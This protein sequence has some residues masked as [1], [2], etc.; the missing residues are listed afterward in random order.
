MADPDA[1]I[2]IPIRV[3]I[4]GRPTPSLLD[5]LENTVAQTVHKRRRE[6]DLHLTGLDGLHPRDREPLRS[7]LAKG[8][9]T[10]VSK[11]EFPDDQAGAPQEEPEPGT[12]DDVAA[13]IRRRFPAPTTDTIRYGAYV[14][15]SGSAVPLLHFLDGNDI[16]SVPISARVTGAPLRFPQGSYSLIA[17]PGG[18]ARIFRGDQRLADLDNPEDLD[19]TVNFVVPAGSGEPTP[20]TQ[21]RYRYRPRLLRVLRPSGE[22]SLTV[23][24]NARYSVEVELWRV[25]GDD[26]TKVT[27]LALIYAFIRYRWTVYHI[28]RN[29]EGVVRGRVIVAHEDAG[30]PVFSHSW[31]KSGEYEVECEVTVDYADASPDPTTESLFEKVIALPVRMATDLALWER[32][33]SVWPESSGTLIEAARIRLREAEA[34]GSPTAGLASG[35]RTAVTEL[36][37]E[38]LGHTSTGPFPI[39][40]IFTERAT[41][42]SHPISLFV[43]PAAGEPY[44][45]RLIDVTYPAFY[46]GEI[47]S[48]PTPASALRAAFETA[49]TSIKNTYPPGRILARI[50]WPGMDSFGISPFD[51][52]IETESFSRTAREWLSAI[53]TGLFVIGV[54]VALATPVTAVVSHIMLAS[55]VFGAVGSVVTIVQRILDGSFDWDRQMAIDLLS[56]AGAVIGGAGTKLGS[57]TKAIREGG[58]LTIEAASRLSRLV[59]FQHGVLYMGLAGDLAN[60]VLLAPEVGREL[61]ALNAQLAGQPY[62]DY[63]ATYGPE[64]G[65]RRWAEE[66]ITRILGILA[67]AAVGGLLI[68]VSIRNNVKAVKATASARAPKPAP[69]PDDEPPPVSGVR[70]RAQ[71]E[72]PHE[73]PKRAT[74]TDDSQPSEERPGLRVLASKKDDRRPR[75]ASRR[76]IAEMQME[77][78]RTRELVTGEAKRDLVEFDED[79][80][81]YVIVR[82]KFRSDFDRPV[83]W[84]LEDVKADAKAMF[85][86][87]LKKADLKRGRQIVG[88]NGDDVWKKEQ[89][90]SDPKSH[91]TMTDSDGMPIGSIFSQLAEVEGQAEPAIVWTYYFKHYVFD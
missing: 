90:A 29:D 54:G 6:F 27:P 59:R 24:A 65:P 67:R 75:K 58:Q 47:G 26:W 12:Q 86:R 32:Q 22:P 87:R 74:G 33:E 66:R 41:G 64:E 50:E 10:E 88:F 28:F 52:A 71:P 81:R 11:W 55:A 44:A 36:E 83:F 73:E 8:I 25:D 91:I 40:A 18:S 21:S 53:S 7:A 79:A 15:V 23:G 89:E 39:R 9:G 63:L 62:T 85:K 30:G 61:G 13:L 14:A 80:G 2:D 68:A 35:L 19:L 43:G 20:P 69:P 82:R 46:R 60:G 49:R 51:F 48:G 1:S 72:Q 34:P 3:R 42:R 84:S 37:Q 56:I 38:L 4:L 5:E 45:W 57:L 78:D 17:R 70:R 31:D 16:R 77:V 76:Q